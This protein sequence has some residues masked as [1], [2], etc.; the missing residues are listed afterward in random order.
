MQDALAE[1]VRVLELENASLCRRLDS[2][3]S[4]FSAPPQADLGGFTAPWHMLR[5]GV[6][7]AVGLALG[8]PTLARALRSY[9][10]LQ[11]S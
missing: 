1:R 5:A 9:L 6:C 2:F 10:E 3:A 7:A 4:K 11:A 8:V